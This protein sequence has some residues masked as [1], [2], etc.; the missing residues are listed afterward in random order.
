MIFWL[1]ILGLIQV[2]SAV[3]YTSDKLTSTMNM[4]T[5]IAMGFVFI[6]PVVVVLLY[7]RLSSVK[8]GLKTAEVKSSS[9]GENFGTSPSDWRSAAGSLYARLSEM[10]SNPVVRLWWRKQEKM[11]KLSPEDEPTGEEEP[12]SELVNKKHKKSKKN[13]K[14]SADELEEGSAGRRNNPDGN[15]KEATIPLINN[16]SIHNQTN[17]SILQSSKVVDNRRVSFAQ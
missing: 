3:R 10:K 14:N 16:S 2:S 5:L 6:V 17:S 7:V 8:R 1:Y 9:A 13:K 11:Y 15:D 12:K 4:I